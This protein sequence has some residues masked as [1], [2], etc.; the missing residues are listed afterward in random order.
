M[1]VLFVC[2][3]NG[4]GTGNGHLCGRTIAFRGFVNRKNPVK[5]DDYYVDCVGLVESMLHSKA[6]LSL[7]FSYLLTPLL[8]YCNGKPEKERAIIG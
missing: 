6:T 5:L 3:A 2:V 7:S 4:A 8:Q 1:R